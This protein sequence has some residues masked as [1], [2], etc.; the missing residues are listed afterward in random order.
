MPRPLL[1]L[2]SRVMK[3][4]VAYALPKRK[5]MK[6]MQDSFMNDLLWNSPHSLAANNFLVEVAKRCLLP[7]GKHASAAY[8]EARAAID[9]HK[10][11]A[12]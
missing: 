6:K 5:Q 11:V 12:N 9:A 8:L 3:K 2:Y 10:C 7:P 1:Q 4:A